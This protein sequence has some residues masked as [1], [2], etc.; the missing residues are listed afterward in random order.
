MVWRKGRTG[1]L[2]A[3]D[4]HHDQELCTAV[5]NV[6]RCRGRHPHSSRP[7]D[8][9]MVSGQDMQDRLSRVVVVPRTSSPRW[10]ATMCS[11]SCRSVSFETWVTWP[12][13]RKVADAYGTYYE[14]LGEPWLPVLL[15]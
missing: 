12:E 3:D 1:N 9:A 4:P 5:A 10:R 2:A 6:P 8:Y 13:R 14:Q 15:P 11:P 7:R